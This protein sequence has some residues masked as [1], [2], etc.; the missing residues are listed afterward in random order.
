MD[1]AR[2]A[3]DNRGMGKLLAV[4]LGFS[5]MAFLAYRAMYGRLPSSGAE[6]EP[7]KQRLENVQNAAKRIEAQQ[8]DAVNRADIPAE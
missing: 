7:P 2:R 3:G 1:A 5:L 4:V 6:P 8:E